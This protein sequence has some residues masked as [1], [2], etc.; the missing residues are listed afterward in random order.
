MTSPL[1]ILCQSFSCPCFLHSFC[2]Y[3][4]IFVHLMH[5]TLLH[6]KCPSSFY[7]FLQLFL[8]IFFSIS[9]SVSLLLHFFCSI[10]LLICPF[11]PLMGFLS[12]L[13]KGRPQKS[14]FFF[15]FFFSSVFSFFFLSQNALIKYLHLETRLQKVRLWL[16][17][18]LFWPLLTAFWPSFDTLW[19]RF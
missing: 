18:D 6:F 3:I 5:G 19:A 9:S 11:V 2:L 14:C 10:S 13:S 17:F 12:S 1:C 16:A 4:C 8:D 7:G 15:F